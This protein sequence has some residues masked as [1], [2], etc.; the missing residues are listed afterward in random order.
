MFARCGTLHPTDVSHKTGLGVK[1]GE[2]IWE[3]NP[4]KLIVAFRNFA[5]SSRNCAADLLHQSRVTL[6][7][8]SV[9]QAGKYVISNVY[10]HDYE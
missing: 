2:R 3:S 4:M 9:F 8:H 6:R 10:I 1:F 7:C 5:N